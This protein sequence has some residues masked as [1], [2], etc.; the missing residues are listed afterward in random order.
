MK[1]LLNRVET[2]MTMLT[3]VEITKYLDI[4]NEIDIL[5]FK[6]KLPDTTI[7]SEL[8]ELIRDIIAIG[9]SA[10]ENGD[11]KGYLIFG[12]DD[13]S[14][15]TIEINQRLLRLKSSDRAPRGNPPKQSREFL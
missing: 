15:Q 7:K 10:F 11:Q 12:I 6:R 5:D 13:Q 1:L 2:F 8:A 14:R 4:S 9:N 3:K